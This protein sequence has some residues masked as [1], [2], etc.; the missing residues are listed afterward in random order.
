MIASPQKRARGLDTRVLLKRPGLLEARADEIM[1]GIERAA[2]DSRNGFSA[3]DAGRTLA[4]LLLTLPPQK[5]GG[6]NKRV[7]ALYA[8]ADHGHWLWDLG[9]LVAQLGDSGPAA[10]PYLLHPRALNLQRHLGG[11]H[12]LCR[13]GGAGR[14]HSEPALLQLWERW[15]EVEQQRDYIYVALRRIGVTPPSSPM[16]NARGFHRLQ[17]EW[18]DVSPDSPARVCDPEAERR[19]RAKE[20]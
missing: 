8:A 13:I 9:P 15:R 2:V 16:R 4:T 1:S 10:A 11:V 20:R 18:A 7:F 5:L 14:I 12:A 19:A 6:F 17:E 3:H